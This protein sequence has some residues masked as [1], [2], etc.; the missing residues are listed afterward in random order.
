MVAN[1]SA[2]CIVN[3][4]PYIDHVEFYNTFE[5]YD[6]FFVVDDNDFDLG[7]MKAEY[8]RI[9]FV[10]VPNEVCH[11]TGF[12][13]SLHMPTSSLVF[14][15][16]VS[17]DKSIYFFSAINKRYDHVWFLED[18]VVVHGENTFRNVDN[19]YPFS[20]LLCRDKTPEP[21]PDEWQWF[22]PAI[23]INFEGPYF[24]SMIC[25]CRMSKK[26]LFCLNEYVRAN[27][28]M[29]FIE[30]M[31][32]SVSHKNNLLCDMPEEFKNI[33]WRREWQQEDFN[34]SDFFHPV[35]NFEAHKTF[36]LKCAENVVRE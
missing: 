21:K 13:H 34:Q 32:P 25:A 30:A 22:W 29:F 35:K 9:N 18:D 10:Q 14:N 7:K 3:R 17:W 19:K 31:F 15:E 2:I 26:F 11:K 16:V 27:N 6:I 8:P 33:V 1:T 23:Q 5:M 24:H 36:R 4:K 12:K 28:T 20:D